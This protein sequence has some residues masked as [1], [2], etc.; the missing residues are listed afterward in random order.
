MAAAPRTRLLQVL[1]A[2]AALLGST[3]HGA[4][5]QSI[6]EFYKGKTISIILFTTPGSIYDTY[7]R[8]L[9]RVLPKHMLGHP[10]VVIKYMSGAGGPR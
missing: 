2:V 4:H 10:T 1:A 5:A 9:A 6:E 8:L 7:A 3:S